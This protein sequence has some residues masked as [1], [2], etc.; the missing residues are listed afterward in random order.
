MIVFLR[1]LE[2]LYSH[3]SRASFETAF[4]AFATSCLDYCNSFLL[5]FQPLHPT[6]FSFCKV[7]LP[8]FFIVAVNFLIPLL[9]DLHW[10]PI[11]PLPLLN[12]SYYFYLLLPPTC[13]PL[14]LHYYI[15]I[16]TPPSLFLL[17]SSSC[18]R[19]LFSRM[20]DRAISV[21]ASKLWNESTFKHSLIFHYLFF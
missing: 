7:L 9:R 1:N 10:F 21:I 4:H 16:T 18:L 11:T 12:P 19:S 2:H 5:D 15:S 14:V 6:L 13:L 17:L 8:V 3:F 20:N